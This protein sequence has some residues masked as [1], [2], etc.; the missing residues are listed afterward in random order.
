MLCSILKE[1]T[2]N[3]WFHGVRHSCCNT[4]KHSMRDNS[5]GCFNNKHD[6]SSGFSAIVCQWLLDTFLWLDLWARCRHRRRCS[7]AAS[8]CILWSYFVQLVGIP[9]VLAPH[10]IP[11]EGYRIRAPQSCPGISETIAIAGQKTQDTHKS[12][13]KMPFYLTVNVAK[14]NCSSRHS[15]T[16]K[17]PQTLGPRKKNRHPNFVN[18]VRL[19]FNSGD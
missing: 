2:D 12:G 5:S 7:L 15:R 1:D 16:A 3:R 4:A 14:K 8:R 17:W 10:I 18:L 19:I 9:S 13:R 11:Q 6:C